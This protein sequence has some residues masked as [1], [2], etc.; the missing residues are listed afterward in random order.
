[1]KSVTVGWFEIPVND[2]DRAIK[3]YEQV[4]DC[5]LNKQ[6]MGDFQMAWFPGDETSQGATG[7]LVYH[8]Q[9]Y[10]T[11]GHAGALVYFSSEDCEIEL[12]KVKD[13]GGEVQIPKR[14]I[15]PDIGFMGVFLDSEGNRI[16]IHS[17]K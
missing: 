2:M 7:S 5:T 17:R 1:M 16:A 8:K 6:V 15:A 9:F 3:F 13:A 12:S 10:E 11:S 14:M 4:F